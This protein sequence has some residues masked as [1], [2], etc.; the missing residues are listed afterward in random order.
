MLVV[1]VIEYVDSYF[2]SFFFINWKSSV[3]E[4]FHSPNL[5]ITSFIYISMDILFPTVGG[6]CNFLG[7]VSMQRSE[8]ADQCYSFVTAQFYLASKGWYILEV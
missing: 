5:F 7:S 4:D 1:I 3:R 6:V 2:T 8:M